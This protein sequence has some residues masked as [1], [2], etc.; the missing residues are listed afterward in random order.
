MALDQTRTYNLGRYFE[1]DI[2]CD[3]LMLRPDDEHPIAALASGSGPGAVGVIRISG[4]DCWTV[5]EPNFKGADRPTERMV[6]LKVFRDPKTQESI[7]DLVVVFF[8]GPRSYTG[9]DTVELYCH[10]GPYI[11]QRILGQLF[12]QGARPAQA[13]EFTKRALLNGKLDLTAA[14]GIKDLV[15]AQSRQQWLAGRQL[16][17]GVLKNEIE[18][19]RKEVIG[20]MAYLEA[21]IDFPD[22]EDTQHVGLS[23]VRARLTNVSTQISSLVSTFQSGRV[24]SR[25]LMV[26]LAGAPNAGK[27]T[28]LNTLLGRP[29]AIVSAT[30]GT[31]RDYIEESCLI[32]G[33]LVRLVDTAGIR[34]TTDQIEREGVSLSTK[35][36]GEADVII[37]LSAV[38]SS[39]AERASIAGLMDDVQKLRHGQATAAVINV[40]T[41]SD[42]D[43]PD[44]ARHMVAI[45]CQTGDGLSDLRRALVKL[46]DE[47]TG[48]LEER[49][50]LTSQRQQSALLSSASALENFRR[51]ELL[52]AGPEMLA[53]ELLEA[54]RALSSVIGDVSNEDILDKVFSEFCIGK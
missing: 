22:E 23:H 51:Q 28:L 32:D 53:F 26:V 27:S 37:T 36:I 2:E 18:S 6:S 43:R 44:W 38:D 35:L 10:G 31:T 52:K 16:Y 40:L 41:K 1:T 8:K 14:E 30:P 13:G 7:D 49:P 19:L 46:V 34:D 25:G 20:A 17:S 29:R 39:S 4:A 24:A 3:H 12:S 47:H 50:F 42:V 48:S 9:Q 45:S 54:A 21:M 15:E 33:R 11:I 5:V